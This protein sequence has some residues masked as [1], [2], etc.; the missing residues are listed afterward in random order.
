L[1]VMYEAELPPVHTRKLLVFEE[2][3]VIPRTRTSPTP[4]LDVGAVA[5]RVILVGEA[6]EVP[7]TEKEPEPTNAGE[8]KAISLAVA[9][10][11]TLE[12]LEA[13]KRTTITSCVV[14]VAETESVQNGAHDPGNKVKLPS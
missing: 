2:T 3:L 9:V 14:M 6:H 5:S 12:E 8:V 13:T 4:I 11:D 10:M 1:I 7:V